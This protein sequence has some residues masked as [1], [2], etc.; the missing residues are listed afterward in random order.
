[1]ME[2][3]NEDDAGRG[4]KQQPVLPLQALNASLL[5]SNHSKLEIVS[6]LLKLRKIFEK[7][8]KTK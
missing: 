4:E 1:M 6:K 5:E 7:K 8:S 3:L 2:L